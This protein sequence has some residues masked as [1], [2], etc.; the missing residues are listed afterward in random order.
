MR[1]TSS[2]EK[3][4]SL[5][6]F[7]SWEK[8]ETH[9]PLP[10]LPSHLA[11]NACSSMNRMRSF[12]LIYPSSRSTSWKLQPTWSEQ[13]T[14]FFSNKRIARLTLLLMSACFILSFFF[15]WYEKFTLLT[16]LHSHVYEW[17][18]IELATLDLKDPKLA[19]LISLTSADRKWMDEVDFLIPRQFFRPQLVEML[20]R[21]ASTDNRCCWLF[22][23][24]RGSF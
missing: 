3:P 20:K 21:L 16:F 10:P 13:Q 2:Y 19:G 9:N 8:W 5:H 18:Q 12:N 15:C 24:R 7:T 11:K 6:I 23:E 17:I 1:R 22:L 14:Q 4:R